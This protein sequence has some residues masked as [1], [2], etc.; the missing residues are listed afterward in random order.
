MG[1]RDRER[2]VDWFTKGVWL[3][4]LLACG[5]AILLGSSIS[6]VLETNQ[7]LL[8]INR[9]AVV[10]ACN[11]AAIVCCVVRKSLE[12]TALRTHHSNVMV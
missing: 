11:V 6:S 9:P 5:V 7:L 10:T 2:S 1:W 12:S 8:P 3:A 4:S